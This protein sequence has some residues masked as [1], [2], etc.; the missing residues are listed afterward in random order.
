V[1]Y[2]V[3]SG[4]ARSSTGLFGVVTL[5]TRLG[6]VT[7]HTNNQRSVATFMHAIEAHIFQRRDLFGGGPPHAF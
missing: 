6:D 4:V 5:S 3:V 2:D 7:V 1:T